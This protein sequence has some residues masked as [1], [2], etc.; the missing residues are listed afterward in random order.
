MHSTKKG[1]TVDSENYQIVR[2]KMSFHGRMWRILLWAWQ[3]LILTV[4]LFVT[5]E[6]SDLLSSSS[7]VGEDFATLVSTGIVWVLILVAWFVGT[8]LF[9]LG[10]FLTRPAK[11][12]VPIQDETKDT[13]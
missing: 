4:F 11:F 5:T 13:S 10:T 1:S 6:A 3:I 8:A 12:V 2:E 7:S 9:A